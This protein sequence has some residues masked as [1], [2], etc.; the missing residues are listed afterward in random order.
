VPS[1]LPARSRSAGRGRGVVLNWTGLSGAAA[2]RLAVGFA[3]ASDVAVVDRGERKHLDR[4]DLD[5]SGPD[6]IPA[7]GLELVPAP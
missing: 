3:G 5:L 7:T 1:E 2:Q 4:I 6:P